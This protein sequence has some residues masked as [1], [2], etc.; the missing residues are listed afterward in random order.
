M[1]RVY[2]S[3]RDSKVE[4]AIYRFV[5][6]DPK[7]EQSWRGYARNVLAFSAVGVLFLFFFQLLQN[8]LPLHLH[9]PATKMTPSLAWNTAVSFVSNTSWQSY[10]GESTLGPLLQMGG[11]AVQSFLSAA[12]GMAVAVALI[13]GFARTKTNELGNFWVDLVRG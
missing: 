11:I 9:D 10:G 3:P 12:V 4:K 6:I 8:K 13:R 5:G 1:F 7:A 2:T